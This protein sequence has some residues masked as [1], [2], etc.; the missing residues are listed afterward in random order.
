MSYHDFASRLLATG[1]VPDPWLKGKPR[2]R[3][4]PWVFT[5]ERLQAVYDAAEAVCRAHDA[6]VRAA[7]AQP[8]LLDDFWMLTPVQ[9]LIFQAAAPHWHAYARADILERDDGSLAVIELNC[10][11]PTGQ[12]EAIALG[13][14]AAEDHPGLLDPAADM[15]GAFGQVWRELLAE[16]LD[17]S[18]PRRV[19][20]VYPTEMSDD[21]HVV[22][23]FTWWLES[24]GHEVVLGSPFDLAGDPDGGV[25]LRGRPVGP[26]LRHYKTDW[27]TERLEVWED[28]GPFPDAEPLVEPLLALCRGMDARRALVVN[29]FGAVV[30]QN[31]RTMA[32][33][34]ERPDLFDA[35][36]R[37]IT[38]RYIP[39]TRRLDAVHP[40][41][42]AAERASWVL[43]SDYGAEG[44]EVLVG[45][46]VSQE[47]WELALSLALPERWVVQRVVAARD[48]DGAQRNL[49]PY[50]HGGRAGGLFVRESA[51]PVGHDAISLPVLVDPAVAPSA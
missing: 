15:L 48:Y 37:A 7:V 11:T 30:A 9:K 25:T 3:Q 20:L 41:Q 40:A 24:L 28:A 8:E 4:A 5:P 21:L 14:L 19:G 12:S 46:A 32:L 50:I 18:A 43:K 29:P 2:C 36:I 22:Q 26:V 34:E 17:P 44:E 39:E 10:D 16:H 51:G 6:A 45:P 35:E 1:L 33:P 13:R 38:Q 27:W 31:K 42:I 47:R 49:G 23:L